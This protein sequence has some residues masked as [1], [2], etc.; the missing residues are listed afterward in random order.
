MVILSLLFAGAAV[1]AP[2]ADGVCNVKSFGATGVKSQLAT[3]AIQAA[4][5]ACAAGGG[6]TVLIPP[7]EYLSGTIHLRSHIRL[8]LESGAT[9]FASLEGRDFDRGDRAALIT[10]DNLEN[11]TLDGRGTVDGQA[12]YEWSIHEDFDDAYIR[13]NMLLWKAQGRPLRRSYPAGFPN[14]VFPKLV[15][16]LR[17]KDVRI[18][19]LSFIRSRSWTIHPYACERLVIDGVHIY[20]SLKEAVWADG[21]DPDGCRDVR[22]AN[23]TI[24]TGDDA[25][26]FYSMDWFGPALPCE[27]ITVTNCRL[28][29]ASSAIKFCDGIKNCVRRVTISNTVITDSNRGLAFMVFDGGT[30]SDVVMSN[31]TIECVRKDW[32]WWGDGDPIHFNVKRRS[33]VDGRHYDNEPPPGRIQNVILRDIVARGQGSSRINGHPQSWL[34]NVTIENLRL[35]LTNAP[36]NPL[37]KADHAMAIRY[38]RNLRLRDV[39]VAWGEPASAKWQSAVDARDVHTADFDGL[40]AGGATP[41]HPAVRLTDA[42]DVRIRNARAKPGTGVFLAVEGKSTRGIEFSAAGLGTNARTPLQRGR[43]VPATAVAAA[44]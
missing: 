7:G 31:L 43:D 8:H 34:D 36:D 26:V 6:G 38:A 18:A 1:A 21:I 24:E 40:Y 12:S 30:V 41:A 44:R 33:E 29:S 11:I 32:F 14:A 13:D 22:I 20:S 19:G 9:L 28:S 23:S 3:P 17:C 10:G 5:D 35:F 25:I 39:E 15:L 42:Q 2:A 27:N 16:L 4:I 37:E